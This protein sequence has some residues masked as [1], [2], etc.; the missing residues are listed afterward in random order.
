[1]ASV[2]RFKGA[3][4]ISSGVVGLASLLV[5][6]VGCVSIGP[7]QELLAARS[8]YSTAER[9]AA[10]S[11]EPEH[12]LSARQALER[13]ERAHRDDPGSREERHLGHIAQRKAKLAITI[14]E[15]TVAKKQKRQADQR[16][17]ELSERERKEAKADL[18]Y[19]TTELGMTEA[20]LA[21]ERR[22]R[23]Q[24]EGELR[25]ALVSLHEMAKV[26]AEERE[27]VIT[28]DGAVLFAQGK[29]EL[30]P[31]A[32][33][34]LRT[35]AQALKQQDVKKPIV[36]EGHTD[37]VGPDAFNQTL[38]QARAEAVRAFLISEGMDASRITA[39]GKGESEPVTDNTSPEGRANNRRVEIILRD[40]DRED[41][42][43]VRGND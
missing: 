11:V 37:D 29:T 16:Y 2:Q 25:N 9:S 43:P 42:Q 30:M 21:A 26:K 10:A 18:A 5:G 1:M 23:S 6:L 20:Q 33:D 36:I 41:R 27:I 24:A 34:K 13:A 4:R 14:A 28:L 17:V 40:V 12:L 7:S 31:I 32:K 8:L 15:G 3:R 22:A 19:T 35:V 38:S 39:I